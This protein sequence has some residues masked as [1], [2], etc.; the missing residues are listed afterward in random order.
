M[1]AY[2]VKRWPRFDNYVALFTT[3]LGKP[4]QRHFIAI[5][6]ALII[7]DG[8]KNLAGLNRA[9]YAPCHL[10]SLQRFIGETTWDESEFEQIRSAQLNRQI[11]RYLQHHRAEG[12]NIPAF[13]CIDDTNNPKSGSHT[14]FASYQY[15]H[16]A[17]GAI[18]C[19]CLVT[20]VLAIGPYVIPLNFRLYRKKAD[21]LAAGQLELFRTKTE[22]AAQ[23]VEEWPPFE[24]TDT[25]VLV[26]SWYLNDTLLKACQKRHFPLI[27]GLSANRSIRTIACP[28]LT[29][30][31]QFAPQLPKEAYHWVKVGGQSF[32]LAGVEAHLKGDWA[33]KLIVSLR[34]A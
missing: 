14:S 25:I 33:V 10:S 29:G 24:G 17:G 8:R 15:S 27:G 11:K 16:L 19:Y 28:S 31:E 9:L 3:K 13:L 6:I 26:D 22:L 21:C 20:A 18:R 1:T 4:A 34:A 12:V 32:N 23:L 7:Y 5:L 30:L 2:I